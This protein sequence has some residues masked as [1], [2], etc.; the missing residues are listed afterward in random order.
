MTTQIQLTPI[1]LIWDEETTL[2]M[3]LTST[4]MDVGSGYD[5]YSPD[6]DHGTTIAVT[7]IQRAPGA[8][9]SAG[10]GDT[11]FGAAGIGID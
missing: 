4:E 8:D 5:N 11:N 9:N 1:P 6:D 3:T 10:V 7:D 2:A